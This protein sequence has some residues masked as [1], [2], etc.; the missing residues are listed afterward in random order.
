MN[1]FGAGNALIKGSTRWVGR[2]RLSG[3]IVEALPL[4]PAQFRRHRPEEK[5]FGK[6]VDNLRKG[7]YY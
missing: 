3:L 4:E 6:G 1:N 5:N 2:M 7:L